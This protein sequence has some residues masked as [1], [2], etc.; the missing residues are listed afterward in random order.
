[1]AGDGR[2]SRRSGHPGHLPGVPWRP[3]QAVAATR[4]PGREGCVGK[5]AQGR[6][7]GR[8]SVTVLPGREPPGRMSSQFPPHGGENCELIEAEPGEDGRKS[9]VP[10]ICVTR[11][12]I[13]EGSVSSRVPPARIPPHSPHTRPSRPRPQPARAVDGTA[14]PFPGRQLQRAPSLPGATFS[15]RSLPGP[16]RQ[17]PRPFPASGPRESTS[18]LAGVS[19][20]YDVDDEGD[21][22]VEAGPAAESGGAAAPD[23]A[24]EAVLRRQIE[25]T[26]RAMALSTVIGLVVIA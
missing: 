1:M 24:E 22:V 14:L 15:G 12:D 4:R 16:R 26:L 23:P 17:S 13:G 11:S 3:W 6:H 9:D 25:Q 2:V 7:E 10:G 8:P 18:R 20:P 5:K 19:N 21:P